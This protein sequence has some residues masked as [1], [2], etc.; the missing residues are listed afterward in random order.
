MLWNKPNANSIILLHEYM[1]RYIYNPRQL[2]V[3]DN[4]Q[5][6]TESV[7]DGALLQAMPHNK[8][9]L[10]QFFGVMKFCLIYSLAHF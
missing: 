9:I 6:M 1:Q 3:F 5:L 2:H 10:I 4:T 8:H 7:I